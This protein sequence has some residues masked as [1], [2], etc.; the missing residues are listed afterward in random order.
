MMEDEFFD[1]F[2]NKLEEGIDNEDFVSQ[3][4]N[5]IE[6]GT[7]RQNQYSKLIKDSFK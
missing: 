6:N 1:K 2:F 7:L 4:K 3:L 5:M